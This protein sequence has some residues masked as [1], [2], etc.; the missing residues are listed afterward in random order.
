MDDSNP[1]YDP[2]ND[3]QF[4]FGTTSAEYDTLGTTAYKNDMIA[5]AC[6]AA[7][8]TVFNG[9]SWDSLDTTNGPAQ[10]AIVTA[11]LRS[12]CVYGAE[13]EQAFSAN[14]GRKNLNTQN[15]RATFI[16][17]A[18]DILLTQSLQK[19]A[20]IDNYASCAYGSSCTFDP[21]GDRLYSLGGMWLI[22]DP[23]YTVAWNQVD[24]GNGDPFMVDLD[25]NWDGL[26]AE[27]TIVP[28]QPYQTA[29]GT[30]ITTLQRPDSHTAFGAPAGGSFVREFAQCYQDG[31]SIG[32]CAVVLNPES[33]DYTSGGVVTMP[34]LAHSYSSSLVLNNQPADAGG[35]ATWTGSVPTSLQPMTAVIL[36]Q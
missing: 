22:Y 30:D 3:Y 18:D 34:T 14:G 31:T 2:V 4:H 11:M 10:K 28:T 27:F 16:P 19:F 5:M 15:E 35:S 33:S 29:T 26:V 17:I 36:K 32:G 20:V 25:G 8:P 1:Y 24:A 23:R 9:P 6:K 7:K 13:V 21:V 12:P